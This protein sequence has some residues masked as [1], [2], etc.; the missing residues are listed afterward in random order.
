MRQFHIIS[1]PLGLRNNSHSETAVVGRCC[2]LLA[3]GG[4]EHRC[5][6]TVLL[7][8]L[9]L[10][11]ASSLEARWIHVNSM[12]LFP[13]LFLERTRRVQSVHC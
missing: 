9:L 3:R 4:F 5:Y 11:L 10:L 8:L 6:S 1:T 13:A 12:H 2:S 7:L